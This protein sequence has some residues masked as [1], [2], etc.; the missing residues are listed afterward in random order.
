MSIRSARLLASKGTEKQRTN[1]NKS[2]PLVQKIQGEELTTSKERPLSSLEAN[3]YPNPKNETVSSSLN[4]RKSRNKAPE[5]EEILLSISQAAK[6]IGVTPTTLRRWEKRGW[7]SP[8]RTAG[9]KRRY[10]PLLIS[11]LK[12]REL[13][14]PVPSLSEPIEIHHLSSKDIVVT[15]VF[16]T[17]IIILIFSLGFLTTTN[18]QHSQ[19]GSGLNKSVAV[20]PEL[21][22]RILGTTTAKSFY[23]SFLKEIP[24]L[25]AIFFGNLFKPQI[26]LPTSPPPFDTLAEDL[27][28]KDADTL[29]QLD[30]SAFVLLDQLSQSITTVLPQLLTAGDGISISPVNGQLSNVKSAQAVLALAVRSADLAGTALVADS[31]NNLNV[32]VGTSGG[33]IPQLDANGQMPKVAGKFI[34]DLDASNLAHGTVSS[35]FLTGSY[36]GITGLGT[37]TNGTWE[38]S[39]IGDAYINDDITASNYLPLGAGT[40]TGQLILTNIP[41][42]AHTGTWAIDSSTWN[43]AD[44]TLYINPASATGD[45]NL[46]G[47]AVGGSV[48]FAVDAEGDIYG[49]NLI[50]T[51]FTTQGTTTVTGD[52]TVEGNTILGDN[53]SDTLTF[54]ARVAQDVDFIPIGTTGTNDLGASALPWDNLYVADI[55]SDASAADAL[56]LIADQGGIDISTGSD[57]HS[58]DILGG[59]TVTLSA[60]NGNITLSSGTGQSTASGLTIDTNGDITLGDSL[61]LFVDVSAGNVGIGT[62]SPIRTLD[63]VGITRISGGGLLV[64][65]VVPGNPA[66]PPEGEV[67]IMDDDI[68][69]RFILGEGTSS[70]ESAGMKWVR[71]GNYLSIYHSSVGTGSIVLDSSGNVGIGTT[72]PS[73]KL[74]IADA[75]LG[76]DFLF[77]SGGMTL[78]GA[79]TSNFSLAAG[80]SI[81]LSGGTG[82]T[83]GSGLTVDTSGNIGI[84]TASPDYLLHLSGQNNAL[85][86]DGTGSSG[87]KGRI[88]FGDA[89]R[90]MIEETN[91]DELHLSASNGIWIDG[92]L[93]GATSDA[94]IFLKAGTD[95]GPGFLGEY[96][97]YWGN[98]YVASLTLNTTGLQLLAFQGG[99]DLSSGSDTQDIDILSGAST[100]IS[101]VEGAA[102]A[103]RLIADQGGIDISTGSDSHSIDILGG[104]TITLKSVNGAITLSAG[105]PTISSGLTIN[106]DG[107]VSSGAD[108][109]S[110]ADLNSG[111]DINVWGGDI[112][113]G[114]NPNATIWM[115]GWAV[116]GVD[117]NVYI[118]TN[119]GLASSLGSYRFN[120]RSTDVEAFDANVIIDNTG[121]LAV[122]L[123]N[124]P[125]NDPSLAYPLEVYDEVTNTSNRVAFINTSGGAY[126]GGD[127]GI[128]DDSPEDKLDIEDANLGYNFLFGSGGM[129]L[130]GAGTSNFSLAAGGSISLSGGTGQSYGSGLTINTSGYVVPDRFL[131]LS[132]IAHTEAGLQGLRLPQATSFIE[133]SS[134]EGFI[135]WD[136]GAKTLQVFDGTS[137]A[138]AS[139][140]DFD[141]TYQTS[142]TNSNL[143]MEIDDTGGLT[144]NMTTTGDFTIQDNGIAI[145]TFGSAGSIDLSAR[146]NAADSIRLFSNL[147]GIDI[148]TGGDTH[149]IDILSGAALNLSAVNGNLSLSS[150]STAT[151]QSGLQLDT[152]GNISLLGDPVTTGNFLDI[153]VDNLTT[154]VG[155]YLESTS[156][157]LS[158]GSLMS[159]Y[160]NPGSATT[161]TGDLFL[162]NVGA[163]ATITGNLLAIQDNASDLFTVS[164]TAIT[165]ALPHSFTAA[166][167]VSIAYDLVLTNQTASKIES[168]GP[169]TI[170]AGESF[171]NNDLTLT[172]NGTGS[173]ILNA[174]TG[175]VTM[176]GGAASTQSGVDISSGTTNIYGTLKADIGDITS[177][178]AMCFDGGDADLLNKQIGDCSG[179]PIADYA[180]MFPVTS[181]VEYG[182]IVVTSNQIVE[183]YADDGQGNVDESLPKRRIPRLTKSTQPY[184]TTVIGIVSNNYGDFSSTGHNVISPEDNP[185]PVALSGRVP[186]KISPS[187]ATIAIGDPL[188]TSSDSGKAIKATNAGVII[189]Q[190]LE[191][192]NPDSSQEQIMMFV[193]NSWHNPNLYLSHTGEV[194]SLSGDQQLILSQLGELVDPRQPSTSSIDEVIA[195]LPE[196]QIDTGVDANLIGTLTYLTKK[197]LGMET[198]LLS[199]EQNQEALDSLIATTNQESLT[200]QTGSASAQ[201]ES[202]ATRLSLIEDTLLLFSPSAESTSSSSLV[203]QGQSLQSSE[204]TSSSSLNDP[205]S[206]IDDLVLD[207]DLALNSNLLVTGTSQ[208]NTLSVGGLTTIGTLTLDPETS[209]I[210]SLAEPLRLQDLAL[211]PILFQGGAAA[212]TPNGD[213]ITQGEI[214]ST[215][216]SAGE[217]AVISG[218]TVGEATILAGQTALIIPSPAVTATSRIFTQLTSP[219]S[220]NLIV[221]AKVEGESFTVTLTQNDTKDITFD[222]WIIQ[223]Q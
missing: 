24:N 171:E 216:V 141:Q 175:A 165:S 64:G 130:S 7:F 68:D 100:N 177:T 168:Y 67:W 111:E 192:W 90:A 105:S 193:N 189:G 211:Q 76:Y 106:T 107:S 152:S 82:Q 99:I 160:W 101:S 213:F 21:S 204:S 138:T 31:S 136:T 151:S 95:S 50:L 161:A 218:R 205:P 44:S 12:K 206:T 46:L 65:D 178:E 83:A 210:N 81:S 108:L 62:D 55:R 1:Q 148:S 125:D 219:T 22:R 36:T 87:S 2:S 52:F 77:G 72:T 195:Q 47:L 34:T 124:D 222:Y 98:S 173:I 97:M 137:W 63:V 57:S 74:D 186:V 16:T 27:E 172:T 162:V 93:Q 8:R 70:G 73:D 155:L 182:D 18:Y 13:Q 85:H 9:G 71:A 154:G 25:A 170:E 164:Q 153:S 187:S 191:P 201:L 139:G 56:Q 104:N 190:A 214:V 146:E 140:G 28:L 180:E 135:A 42:K 116:F 109:T 6:K 142:I 19:I 48:K 114:S 181:D 32:D 86:I 118:N 15:R 103:L 29:D 80:G 17:S 122:G 20:S 53:I 5:T 91:D 128:G 40:L 215:K 143:T 49:N 158:S 79:G 102:D 212:L 89:D 174:A 51:G 45:S 145:A 199:L 35:D 117:T 131:D 110:G 202:M 59:N 14:P 129:T 39:S 207:Q 185:F 149:P 156:T 66:N 147:G 194:V 92:S 196:P 4:N 3:P 132:A 197:V 61:D 217:F 41:T 123:D 183:I 78:S 38:G 126:F 120:D 58:I 159:L 203:L 223:Q 43:V 84:G 150:G 33:Q 167:D 176:S 169:L 115:N 127:V 69:V 88:L 37:I 209:S 144:F 121:R 188:T 96:G 10:T 163:N 184:Q 112:F 26:F 60:I 179:S 54:N 113:F 200:A 134:G 11:Q 220:A 198:Q 221:T 75:N 157:A 166:G 30:S 208:L 23:E 94:Q 119:F 133:P